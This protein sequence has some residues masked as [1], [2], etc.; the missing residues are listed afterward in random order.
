MKLLK[1]KKYKGLIRGTVIGALT[2]SCAIAGTG[3]SELFDVIEEKLEAAS[4]SSSSESSD[5]LISQ[6]DS[7]I[8]EDTDA[9]SEEKS[10]GS[11]T[12]T[13][14]DA[15]SAAEESRAEESD[16]SD[17]EPVIRKNSADITDTHD[18]A[19]ETGGMN[20]TTDASVYIESSS[21]LQYDAYKLILEEYIEKFNDPLSSYQDE[22]CR[23]YVTDVE[24][25]GINELLVEMGTCEADRSVSIYKFDGKEAAYIGSFITWKATLGGGNGENVIYSETAT[26]GNYTLNTVTI[27]NGEVVFERGETTDESQLSHLLSFYALDDASGIE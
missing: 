25:D 1:S 2:V 17:S 16:V 24:N 4:E 5:S 11:E 26:M 8:T 7:A 14:N 3:C 10:G 22:Y 9:S 13:E 18:S 27:E 19:N 23:Y 12:E 21:G 20:L 15:E 6:T